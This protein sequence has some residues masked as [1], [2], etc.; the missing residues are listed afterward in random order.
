MQEF[1]QRWVPTKFKPYNSV[2]LKIE[3][4]HLH[5]C[6]L[7]P[8]FAVVALR[9]GIWAL[10]KYSR[11][12]YRIESAVGNLKNL[13]AAAATFQ[14]LCKLFPFYSQCTFETPCHWNGI[15]VSLSH[16]WSRNR[17][18]TETL[19]LGH[20][21]SSRFDYKVSCKSQRKYREDGSN[22]VWRL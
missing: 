16:K 7:E 15:T 10:L 8:N 20:L 5:T 11:V 21:S 3:C 4:M 1:R 9:F 6:F 12:Y 18:L 2:H 17:N 13:S 14:S 19:F 22:H